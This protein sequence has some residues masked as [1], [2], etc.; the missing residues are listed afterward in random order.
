MVRGRDGVE[1]EE[2]CCCEGELSSR[3]L[4]FDLA[5]EEDAS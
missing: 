3:W 1:H 2:T 4:T 5:T